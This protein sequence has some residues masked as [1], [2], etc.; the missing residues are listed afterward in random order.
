MAM[1]SLQKTS[2]FQVLQNSIMSL[3][4]ITIESWASCTSCRD[5]TTKYWHYWLKASK[6]LANNAIYVF[7]LLSHKNI[8]YAFFFCYFWK[9]TYLCK[10]FG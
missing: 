8:K 6:L 2:L 1:I 3:K 9:I 7:M 4:K 5:T 10:Q